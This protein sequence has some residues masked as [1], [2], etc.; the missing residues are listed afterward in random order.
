[1]EYSLFSRDVEAG[2]LARLNAAMPPGAAHGSRY[3]EATMARV[4]A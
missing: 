4:N 2:D 3:P 1:M